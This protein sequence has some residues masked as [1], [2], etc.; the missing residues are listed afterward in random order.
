MKKLLLLAVLLFTAYTT[1]EKIHLLYTTLNPD[2]I[3]SH[4]AFYKLFPNSPDGKKALAEAWKLLAK[5]R[6]S[7]SLPNTLLSDHSI[8]SVVT[9][10]TKAEGVE[11]LELTSDELTLIQSI[12]DMLPNK[13]L[14]CSRA[15]T[16]EEVLKLP[17]SEID[18]SRAYY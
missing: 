9:L 15:K 8:S 7:G 6:A 5:E 1:P 13:S 10:I 14:E 3:S 2:S 16:E 12:T 17:S 4:L 18:L 11:A